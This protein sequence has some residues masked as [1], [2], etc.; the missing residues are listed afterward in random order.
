MYPELPSLSLL[1]PLVL[2]TLH[3]TPSHRSPN[4]P[5]ESLPVGF[6]IFGSLLIQRIRCVGFQ[7]EELVT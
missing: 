3:L 6:E 7:E 5:L 2:L 4:I 1:D